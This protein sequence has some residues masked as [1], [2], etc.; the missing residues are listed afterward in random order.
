MDEAESGRIADMLQFRRRSDEGGWA[1]APF[2]VIPVGKFS[3]F[4]RKREHAVAFR[5]TLRRRGIRVVSITEHAA[6]TPSGKLMEAIIKSVDE[7]CPRNFSWRNER[8]AATTLDA[9][10]RLGS[11]VSQTET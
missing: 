7:F 6:D 9:R 4:T 11:F 3:R 2:Q 5:S 10:A 1:T 8:C